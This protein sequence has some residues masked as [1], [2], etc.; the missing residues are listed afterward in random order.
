[1]DRLVSSLFGWCAGCMCIMWQNIWNN[2]E[3]MDE[4]RRRRFGRIYG[5]SRIRSVVC[6]P[7]H[8][9]T[10][11]RSRRD[12]HWLPGICTCT[13]CLRW[14]IAQDTHKVSWGEEEKKGQKNQDRE[15]WQTTA[16]GCFS[17]SRVL[18]AEGR[19]LFLDRPETSKRHTW[20]KPCISGFGSALT[21][22]PFYFLF[23]IFDFLAGKINHEI[24]KLDAGNKSIVPTI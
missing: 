16:I 19:G 20:E 14:I 12:P 9:R 7:P 11:P 10:F 6:G 24:M 2:W 8:L 17:E 22:V 21:E 23:L 15:Q 3:E 13:P 5:E 1:M 18:E 4:N